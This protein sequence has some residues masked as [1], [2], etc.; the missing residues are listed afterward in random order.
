VFVDVLPSSCEMVIWV[1]SA[2]A[3]FTSESI[4]ERVLPDRVARRYARYL[5]ELLDLSVVDTPN[6]NARVAY[7]IW[8]ANS[9]TSPEIKRKVKSI[10]GTTEK[11]L[12]DIGQALKL[13]NF[14]TEL[15]FGTIQSLWE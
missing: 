6:D 3:L 7:E 12:Q 2:T 13:D 8:H 14:D 10:A 1:P 15:M 4:E 11:Y 5:C 9:E